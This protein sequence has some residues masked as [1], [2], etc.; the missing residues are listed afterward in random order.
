M[1]AGM[2]D[3]CIAVAKPCGYESHFITTIA[4]PPLPFINSWCLEIGVQNALL[5]RANKP[6]TAV[7]SSALFLLAPHGLFIMTMELSSIPPNVS[8]S[9]LLPIPRT[10]DRQCWNPTPRAEG[11]NNPG[12]PYPWHRLQ[13]P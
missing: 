12:L 5:M 2:T 3:Q 10:S 6:E 8:W 9:L 7:Q 11:Q 13:A 1:N 4:A